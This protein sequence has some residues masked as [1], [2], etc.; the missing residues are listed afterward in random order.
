MQILIHSSRILK[1]LTR[2][3]L[4]KRIAPKSTLSTDHHLSSSSKV[5]SRTEE[6]QSF[7]KT[8][9]FASAES[10]FCASH[11]LIKSPRVDYDV[12]RDDD[13]ET[14]TEIQEA[15]DKFF[16]HLQSNSHEWN[17]NAYSLSF[18]SPETDFCNPVFTGMLTEL[19]KR[20]LSNTSLLATVPNHDDANQLSAMNTR[21]NDVALPISEKTVSSNDQLEEEVENIFEYKE[22]RAHADLLGHEDPL[23]INMQEATKDD[24]DRAIV[25]TEAEIPFRI[26]NVNT[27]WEHLCGFTKDECNGK[28]LSCIQGHETNQAAV[29]A[30]MSQLLRGEEA[31]TVLVNY[32]KDGSKFLNRLRVGALRDDHD[33]I[34]HFVGVLKE[35][36]EVEDQFGHGS[37]ILA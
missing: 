5:N 20:Q 37:R 3:T 21:H 2:L 10:D 14:K 1:Q 23:P 8:I 25:V 30:L 31:G 24:D 9:S 32:R 36:R 17:N 7:S 18:A 13:N 22:L 29:T 34:T 6:S 27:A 11:L 15:K 4:S 19:Q 26:V 33:V 12:H 28:T 35:V 16:Q